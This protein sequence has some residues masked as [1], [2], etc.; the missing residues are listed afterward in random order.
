MKPILKITSALVFA[1][2]ASV[3]QASAQLLTYDFPPSGTAVESPVEPASVNSALTASDV[4][5]NVNSDFQPDTN[6]GFA[7]YRAYAPSSPSTLA[8][9]NSDGNY[10]TFT[11]T[12]D[13]GN[14]MTLTYLDLSGTALYAESGGSFG[15]ESSVDGFSSSSALAT[16]TASDTAMGT[17]ISLG[18]NYANLTGPVEFRVYSYGT[19]PYDSVAL[20][21]SLSVDGTVSTA[22]TT[23]EPSTYALLGLGVFALIFGLR[24]R[25]A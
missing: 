18:S 5:I 15:I 25:R 13:A 6:A 9:A 7:G 14:T 11:I 19:G 20:Q 8:G 22:A 4:T 1:F 17:V 12:P 24:Q 23:P 2:V 16:Y 10:F 21:N 3:T